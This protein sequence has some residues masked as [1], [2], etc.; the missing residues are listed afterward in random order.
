MGTRLR[1]NLDA[2]WSDVDF[3]LCFLRRP[4]KVGFR[5]ILIPQAGMEILRR[6]PKVGD[7]IFPQDSDPTRPK[8]DLNKQWRAVMKFAGLGKV[9]MH[10]LRH[11]FASVAILTG[12]S[13]LEIV[14]K[15]LGHTQSKTTKRYA[16]IGESPARKVL[17]TSANLIGNALD[18]RQRPE[19]A[20][21]TNP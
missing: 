20:K 8:S 18:R 17:E 21:G 6:M 14:G 1:E 16:H 10:D 19:E 15:L 2:N 5:P 4:T 13:S 11:S 7:Y 3:E 9:R 12:G